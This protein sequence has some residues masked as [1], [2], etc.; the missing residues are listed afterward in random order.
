MAYKDW[1]TSFQDAML[2]RA[3]SD[4]FIEQGRMHLLFSSIMCRGDRRS[5]GLNILLDLDFNSTANDDAIVWWT[6]ICAYAEDD[7]S[8]AST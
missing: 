1:L 4:T 5:E 7:A 3:R 6:H 2:A 8:S